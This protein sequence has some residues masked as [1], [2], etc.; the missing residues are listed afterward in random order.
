LENGNWCGIAV[1][2]EIDF[3]NPSWAD[4]YGKIL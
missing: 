1:E 4:P 2:Q 3:V